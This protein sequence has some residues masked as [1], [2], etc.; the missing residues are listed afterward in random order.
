M[1]MRYRALFAALAV[2]LA[3]GAAACGGGGSSDNSSSSGNKDVSGSISMMAI[4]AGEE[5]TSFQAVIDGFKAKYPNVNVK[6]TSGGDNLAPLLSTAVAGGK[7][8][9]IAALGQPGLVADFAKKKAIKPIDDLKSKIVDAFGDDVAKA[10]QVDGT[11][12][13]VMFKGAN[14]STIWY[15]VADFKEAGVEP[16]K[17]WPD[18]T[19]DRDTLKA[20]GITPYSVGV[21]VGWPMTDI[22]EN[23]YLRT[24]GPDMYDKLATH[25]IPWTDPSVKKALT[26]MKDIVGKSDYMVGGTD[27]ALQTEMPTSVSAVFSDNP[28]GAMVVI[29]DFAPGVTKT[30]LSPVSGFN[31]FDFPSINGSKP[32]VVGG[33]D[34]FVQFKES[35]A[36][37]AFLEYLTTTDAAEIW[38]KRGGF[39]SPNKHLDASVY[40]D[41]ITKKTATALAN[42]ETFRFDLSDL[43]PAAFG[44]TPGQGLFKAFSDF[45]ANPD[46]IDQITQKMEAD[47]TKAY[48]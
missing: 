6:Y 13:A 1:K 34:L 37:K 5:Q 28:K 4:W 32:S 35:A 15:N 14:K 7:P 3:L 8:P 33:G 38:A 45:V 12:Y 21:D 16:A 31:V 22:F 2:G 29:G 48:K 9:D 39:S 46:N 10:G 43:Q 44:A 27:A 41:E 23:I 36:S 30:T 26:M 40:P 25:Q 47:A 11:Q 24:A 17:T 18:L 20:A 42:A 19:K